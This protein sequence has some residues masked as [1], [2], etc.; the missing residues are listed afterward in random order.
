PRLITSISPAVAKAAMESGVARFPIEDWDAYE[1]E[2][3][4]RIGIDQK[5]MSR[6][7]SRAKKDPK[8][9]VFA[10]ADNQKVLKAALIVLEEG[11]G[12]PVLLGNEERILQLIE[13]NQLD[14]L[15]ECPII[16]PRKEEEK[17]A[18]FGQV[19]YEKRKRKG[20]TPYEATK[21][22]RD[23]NYFGAMLVEL[24][25]A[26]A[27]ISGLTKDYPKT[28]TPALQVIGIN[29]DIGR[30]AGMYILSN[31]KGT[32]FFSDTTL[33][34]NPT[35]DQLVDIIGNTA[36]GVRFFG[37]E[38]RIAVLSYSNFGSSKGDVPVKTAEAAAKAREKWPDLIVEGDIQANIALNTRLQQENY[39]FSALA[40]EG[41][42]TLIFPDLAS[43]NIAYKLLME[44]GGAEGIG[45]VLLGM[46]K[47]VHI[48]QLGSSI[49][50]IV[51]MVSIA[52]VDA[53]S[54]QG[55]K[56]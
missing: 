47:P 4:R 40:K 5:L 55:D 42:N 51:N 53:Q 3:Q 27:L 28:I 12:K 11:I 10:E 9:V 44:M 50:D 54:Q 22:M 38:P 49:R 33:N 1:V 32:W 25:E 39:P 37:L 24:G 43:G 41:A 8:R 26:D 19:L 17:T 13:E 16:D 31:N 14:N 18:Q 46:N 7:I 48:L 29:P 34:V 6:V 30:V 52:V 20:V 36:E 2:L 15:R 23:R 35:A 21:L 56:K 45:P